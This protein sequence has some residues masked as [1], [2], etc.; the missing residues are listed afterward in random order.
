M[1][2]VCTVCRHPERS[3]IDQLLASNSE[4]KRNISSRFSISTGALSRHT[5]GCLAGAVAQAKQE[6]A[7]KS[8]IDVDT[9]LAAV[10]AAAWSVLK[11]AKEL[12]DDALLLKA[13]DRLLRQITLRARLDGDL[14]EGQAP[15]GA[16]A[17]VRRL[18]SELMQSLGQW[19]EARSVVF[20]LLL[21]IE[22]EVAP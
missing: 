21:R 11:R 12:N 20:E 15:A 7:R 2:R 1:P 18:K 14:T 22:A 9:Q 8:S 10:N 17:F 19:P 4:T 3:T 13:S 6:T 16:E 5:N